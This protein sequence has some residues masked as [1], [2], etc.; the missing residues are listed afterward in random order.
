M[1]SNPSLLSHPVFESDLL[2]L[3]VSA[4]VSWYQASRRV[5]PWH[6]PVSAYATWVCEVMSQQTVLKVVVPKFEAFIAALPNV[7]ALAFVSEEK[8]RILWAGLGYYARAR[9]LQKGAQYILQNCA[10]VLPS[11]YSEW[12]K[13]PGCGPYTASVIASICFGEFSACVDGNVIRVVSRLLALQ[14]E[15]WL[16]AGQLK[17]K[18]F[19]QTEILKSSAPGDFNQAIMELGATHCSRQ[20]P[21]CDLCPVRRS[22]AASAQGIVNLCPPVKPRQEW[23][24]V[25]LKAFVLCDSSHQQVLLVN[26]Q[27]GFLARTWG[28]P[29]LD[30]RAIKQADA[31]SGFEKSAVTMDFKVAHT[32]TNHRIQAEVLKLNLTDSENTNTELMNIKNALHFAETQWVDVHKVTTQ[33]SSSLD[34]K[35]WQ[36]YLKSLETNSQ[37]KLF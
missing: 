17:I 12:L 22:C 10:G 7:E 8:L 14:Q 29:L 15:A 32:I 9:N 35:L 24:E 18:N 16:P 3:D 5:F 2:G 27:K 31:M 19:V 26:R 13:V 34:K 25:A 4:L 33:L 20:S 6:S 1:I 36:A 11:T 23:K 30:T 21:R 37:T 28:L